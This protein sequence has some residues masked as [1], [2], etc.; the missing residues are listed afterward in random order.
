MSGG[1][2]FGEKA[3]AGF[4]IGEMAG[5]EKFER[6][7]SPKAV[8]AGAIDYSDAAAGNFAEQLVIL[9]AAD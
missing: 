3:L 6:D 5:Q 9:D 1:G 7:V 4:G 8:L 2:G